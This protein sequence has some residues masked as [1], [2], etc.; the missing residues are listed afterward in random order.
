MCGIA[1][2]ILNAPGHVGRDL[3]ELMEAQKHRGGVVAQI[4]VWAEGPLSRG[5]SGDRLDL[6]PAEGREAV[7]DCDADLDF[8][9]LAVGVSGHDPLTEAL[10]AVHLRLDPTSDMVARPLLPE[11]PTEVPSCA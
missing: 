11:C 4:S 6:G 2:R 8:G 3:V 9:G 7:H 10:Q 5:S 1:G